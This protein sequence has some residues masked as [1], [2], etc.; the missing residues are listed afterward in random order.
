MGRGNTLINDDDNNYYPTFYIDYYE[1]SDEINDDTN[2]PYCEN[3]NLCICNDSF[4]SDLLGNIRCSIMPK[5]KNNVI[6]YFQ[7]KGND[8]NPNPDYKNFCAG[9]YFKTDIFKVIITDNEDSI[10][11]GC[12]PIL[13]ENEKFN[14]F[15]F[16]N[17]VLK[18]FKLL[19]DMYNLRVRTSAWTSREIVNKDELKLLL[20]NKY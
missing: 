12:V 20:T 8:N 5:F 17:S 19:I 10:A 14:S 1:H 11:I 9:T 7:N 16:N 4:V 15:I 13:N 18:F 3:E 2:E 6:V